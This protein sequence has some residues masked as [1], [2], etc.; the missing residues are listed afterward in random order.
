M[1]ILKNL[2]AKR[3]RVCAKVGGKQKCPDC[4]SFSKEPKRIS[5]LHEAAMDM[6]YNDPKLWYETISLE[7]KCDNLG[8]VKASE[9]VYHE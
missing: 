6:M 1:Q 8:G 5:A 7:N 2:M 4:R 9:K 3:G